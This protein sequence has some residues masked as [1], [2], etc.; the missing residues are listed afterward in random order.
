MMSHSH[1]NLLVTT[2]DQGEQL[3]LH[4][5]ITPWPP[6]LPGMFAAR[7][8]AENR[9]LL[10]LRS[11]APISADC[12]LSKRECGAGYG[13]RLSECMQVKQWIHYSDR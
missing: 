1:Q 13:Y 3:T 4:P 9:D 6:K 8:Q 7:T 2:S 11:P 5:A 12:S 10:H